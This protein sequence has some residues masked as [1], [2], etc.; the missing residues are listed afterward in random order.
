MSYKSGDTVLV[1]Y[2]LISEQA[3]YVDETC[4]DSPVQITLGQD[5]V[6]DWLESSLLSGELHTVLTASQVEEIA[7]EHEEAKLMMMP[8]SE[9]P[10]DLAL[11]AGLIMAFSPPEG[12]EIVGRI[13]DFNED[14]VAV[15]FNHPFA[16]AEVVLE[17][18]VVS[19][20]QM[21]NK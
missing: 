13:D 19:D 3:Q 9:F 17:V 20:D 18:V 4:W 8:R 12:D 2:R 6:P 7:G 21:D 10:A 1:R 14:F 16:G 5:T 11:E 15:D